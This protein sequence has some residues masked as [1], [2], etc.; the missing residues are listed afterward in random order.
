MPLA[1]LLSILP[2]IQ[3]RLYSIASSSRMYPQGIIWTSYELWCRLTTGGWFECLYNSQFDESSRDPPATRINDRL[4]VVPGP[5][6]EYIKSPTMI[7]CRAQSGH[8]HT[9]RFIVPA[10]RPLDPDLVHVIG[11]RSGSFPSLLA[12]ARTATQGR[13]S[14]RTLYILLWL[15]IWK[16]RFCLWRLY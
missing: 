2:L 12:R 11:Y 7:I 10:W 15:P 3:P 13:T 9:Q 4:F 14:P 6:N 5:C 8:V 1:S 16:E